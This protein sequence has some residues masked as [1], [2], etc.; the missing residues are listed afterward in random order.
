MGFSIKNYD[1]NWII[2]KKLNLKSHACMLILG[3]WQIFYA[4]C[5]DSGKSF[6][7]QKLVFI[8]S[9]RR[10]GTILIVRP[11]VARFLLSVTGM[12]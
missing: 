4:T 2:Y 9:C 3:K 10:T 1:T 7:I 6:V 12:V 5:K 8:I 11:Q